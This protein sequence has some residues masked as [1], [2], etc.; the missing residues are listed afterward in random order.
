MGHLTW[1]FKDAEAKE[2]DDSH[3]AHKPLFPQDDYPLDCKCYLKSKHRN[4]C[5]LFI[6]FFIFIGYVLLGNLSG[7]QVFV[8]YTFVCNIL[9]AGWSDEHQFMQQFWDS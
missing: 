6:G 1:G 2:E 5:Y 3:H 8:T 7:H 9:V 4:Y